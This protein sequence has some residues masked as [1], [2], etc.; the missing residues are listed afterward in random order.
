MSQ[1][2]VPTPAYNPEAEPFWT[3]AASGRLV[4]PRCEA[5]SLLIWYPR[6]W[7][8]ACGNDGVT[9]IE[10][11]GEGTVYARTVLH[12][13]MGAWAGAAPFVVAYVEL[14]EG[15]RILTNVVTDDPTSV[16]VGDRVQAVF[17]PIDDRP[18]D[19]PPQAVLRFVPV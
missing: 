11:G 15:P 2:P 8:P 19:A 10:L 6:A 14:A 13:A 16:Q 1:L 4:L 5:C 3:A 7:C 17:E 9:W 12:R 18:E